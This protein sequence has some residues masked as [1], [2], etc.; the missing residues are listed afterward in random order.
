MS[1]S[2][3][4]FLKIA[5]ETV[6]GYIPKIKNRVIMFSDRDFQLRVNSV[7]PIAII[8]NAALSFWRINSSVDQGLFS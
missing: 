4:S 6:G 3:L 5:W 8:E 7:Y 1:H 2:G